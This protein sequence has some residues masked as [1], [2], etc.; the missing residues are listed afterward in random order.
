MNGGSG[1]LLTGVGQPLRGT[2]P[3]PPEWCFERVLQL[4]QAEGPSQ[5]QSAGA[6]R[7]AF[8]RYIAAHEVDPVEQLRAEADALVYSWNEEGRPFLSGFTDYSGLALAAIKR[9]IELA[10]EQAG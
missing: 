10:K 9:G 6:V 8:A 1:S 2:L 7:Q 5:H 3:R 4:T